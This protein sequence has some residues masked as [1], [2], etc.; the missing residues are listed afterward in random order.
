MRMRQIILGLILVFST[1][2][3]TLGQEKVKWHTITEA[4]ELN[5]QEPR[6]FVIDVFTDWCGWCKRMDANTF[7]HPVVAEYMNMHFYPVKLD[8]EGKEDITIG[9][10]TYKFVD[11]GRRG[12]H[13][14]AAAILQ[15]RLS[16]PSIAYLNSELKIVQVVPGYKDAKQFEAY[17]AYFNEQ[18]YQTQTFM[19]FAETFEGK[20]ASE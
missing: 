8:G 11:N 10:H 17:L 13:E 15:G 19:Q 5:E 4:V 1:S 12:Y 20:I 14:L 18:A 6:M 16:Y 2:L 3:L 9:N 7:S